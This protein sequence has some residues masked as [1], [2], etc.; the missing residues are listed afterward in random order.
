M[1]EKNYKLDWVLVNK[2]GLG[3]PPV[4]KEDFLY[5]KQNGIK[6][7]LNLCEE[8]ESP[9]KKEFLNG[10]TFSR[11]TLP[12]H[13][14]KKKLTKNQIFEVVDLLENFI[15]KGPVYVHCYASIERS[16]LVCI[17]W[18]TLRENVAFLNA[19]DHLKQVHK[20]SNPLSQHLS[21]LRSMV[22]ND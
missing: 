2:L 13:K 22:P 11:Y 4:K 1:R 3:T 20:E 8:I 17:A 16:P 12:D 7:I 14:V 5:L 18:L 6:T 10:M 21:L 15:K 19:L 9:I